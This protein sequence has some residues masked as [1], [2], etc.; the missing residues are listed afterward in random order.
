MCR[1]T[2]MNSEISE[3]C[4]CRVLFF[5][6]WFLFLWLVVTEHCA[7]QSQFCKHRFRSHTGNCVHRHMWAFA[8][9]RFD[10]LMLWDTS[11]ARRLHTRSNLF[12]RCCVFVFFFFRIVTFLLVRCLG[13][14][15][16]LLFSLQGA[17]SSVKRG[18]VRLYH[19][20]EG[21]STVATWGVTVPSFFTKQ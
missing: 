1:R 19:A 21:E 5:H 2:R 6:P 10:G 12:Q 7:L 3:S 15:R 16:S 11:A 4:T 14:C 13:L 18:S 17:C 8:A 20:G 9:E